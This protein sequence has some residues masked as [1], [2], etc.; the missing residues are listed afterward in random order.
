MRS[1]LSGYTLFVILVCLCAPG[2][3]LTV[4]AQTNDEI[5]FASDRDGNFEIYAMS[6]DGST[7]QRLTHHD[8]QDIDPAWSPDRSQIAF[9][10]NRDGSFGIYVMNADGSG[11]RRVTPDE[12]NYY[13]S[14]AWSPDGRS[15]AFISDRTGNLDVHTVD[16]NTLELR[17]VTSDLAEDFDPSW[18]SDG[19]TI[20]Y[21]SYRDGYA[22]IYVADV[23]GAQTWPLIAVP[24]ADASAPAQSPDGLLAYVTTETGP[25]G[26]Y[27]DL[28]IASADGVTERQLVG[29]D[30]AFIKSP[31][32]SPD[33]Q[34]LAYVLALM[35]GSSAVYVVDAQ[36][37]SIRQ[38][39]PSD[40][41]AEAPNWYSPKSTTAVAAPV[42]G[43]GSAA[44]A[45]GRVVFIRDLNLYLHDV[46]SVEAPQLVVSTGETYEPDL[47]GKWAVYASARH[48][49]RLDLFLYDLETHTERQLTTHDGQDRHPSF[50]PDGQ[51]IAFASNRMG[52][53]DI[54][55]INVD[56][57][58]LQQITFSP[59][60]EYAPTWSAD[61]RSLA[62]QS[63]QMGSEEIFI[64][65]LQT[66]EIRQLTNADEPLVGA[67]WSPDGR[68]IAG[69]ANVDPYRVFIADS[70]TG[71][72]L[73]WANGIANEWL[74][75]ETL[76]F[77]R[78]EGGI[79][80]LYTLDVRSG[81]E[82]LLIANGSWSAAAN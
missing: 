60:H 25:A 27:S 7:V 13:D 20:L 66:G 70:E 32:W 36:G 44:S 37:Q 55:T 3:R 5:V 45:A 1:W 63:N 72:I 69:Y 73:M 11:V 17:A 68:Y 50:S 75:A 21:T 46:Q 23:F 58:N 33:G 61:G 2:L 41:R 57:S 81:V 79:P 56:G 78:Q 35:D 47:W 40:S 42:P 67:L 74:D 59:A 30:D 31:S 4:H 76:I 71:A 6:L 14:P 18:S 8:A 39:T 53:W 77:H 34:S 48:G 19:A 82:S 80:N 9:V 62:Y 65:D 51:R 52:D 43:R 16:L 38:I 22:Q 26:I 10:S 64:H 24:Q 15:L 28:I 49:R 29:V 12:S 54:F